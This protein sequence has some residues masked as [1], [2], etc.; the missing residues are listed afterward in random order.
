MTRLWKVGLGRYGEFETPALEHNVLTI[1]FGIKEDVAHAKDRDAFVKVM[2][3]I[4][5]NDKSKMHLNRTLPHR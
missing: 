3:G 1:D 5:P 2:E 4:F